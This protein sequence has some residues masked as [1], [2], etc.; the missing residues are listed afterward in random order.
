MSIS[1]NSISKFKRRVLPSLTEYMKRE[2]KHLIMS[3]S[4]LIIFYKGEINEEKIDLKGDK[5]VL[6]FFKALWFNKSDSLESME[7]VSKSV[8]SRIDFGEKI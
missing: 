5:E 3:L 4:A 8:L 2:N 1:L 7:L 6:D